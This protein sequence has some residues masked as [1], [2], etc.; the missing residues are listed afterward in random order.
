MKGKLSIPQ[1]TLLLWDRIHPYNAVHIVKI[2]CPPEPER[3]KE[4]VNRC[5]EAK[6]LTGLVLDRDSCRYEF[7]GGPS[8]L[9]IEVINKPGESS[10]ALKREVQKQLNLR[11]LCGLRGEPFRFFAVTDDHFFYFGVVYFH[12]ISG[13]DS[14]IYLMKDI[15]RVYID[16]NASEPCRPLIFYQKDSLLRRLL[17]PGNLYRWIRALPGHIAKMRRSFRPKY[18]DARDHRTGFTF[19][20]IPSSQMTALIQRAKRWDVTV[21]DMFLAIL[22]VSLAPFADGR[23]SEPRRRRLSLGSVVNIRKELSYND[24][25]RFG[26][27]LGTFVVSH[28]VPEGIKLEDLVKDLK[29]Q[30]ARIKEDKFYLGSVMDQ[31]LAILMIRLLYR[32]R[33]DSF[34][35]KNYPLL[36]GISNI[37]LDSIWAQPEETEIE[38]LR[39]VS[40][41]PA[42][43]LVFSLTTAAG[44]LHVGVSYRETV[45]SE[46]DVEII[47][48]DFSKYIAGLDRMEI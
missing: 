14:I 31:W 12:L 32:N 41:G 1:R 9:E 10:S 20:S 19:F 43:P 6:G 4:I 8:R 27:F 13:G 40:T 39:T 25:Q 3:L 47:I 2:P 29:K 30:T 38:Y 17:Y 26:F 35:S 15:V 48:T 37:N 44:R 42:T 7:R 22:L 28:D 46:R 5:L 18:G 21:N 11:F 23:S 16:G 45:F 24:P 36:G 34:Y 33:G